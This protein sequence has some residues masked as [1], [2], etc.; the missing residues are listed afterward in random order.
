M[1]AAGRI[2]ARRERERTMFGIGKLVNGRLIIK[3]GEILFILVV[4]FYLF[5]LIVLGS[6]FVLAL[7]RSDQLGQQI[8]K[9]SA[10]MVALGQRSAALQSESNKIDEDIASLRGDLPADVL[11]VDV[12]SFIDRS[13]SESGVRIA[14]VQWDPPKNAGRKDS[15]LSA[16]KLKLAVAG[17]LQH[18]AGF[19]RAI[20]RGQ[21][22]SLQVDEVSSRPGESVLSVTLFTQ[23]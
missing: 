7:G 14:N 22:R 8:A 1:K 6:E 10:E 9:T 19:I 5:G 11:T 12:L 3:R 20:E 17:D 16:V 13:A 23:Q 2:R 18:V 21:Y 4:L 15:A